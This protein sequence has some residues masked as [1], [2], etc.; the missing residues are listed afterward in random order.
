ML[1]ELEI[2]ILVPHAAKDGKKTRF[3]HEKLFRSLQ[4]CLWLW[5]WLLVCARC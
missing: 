5:V 4:V 1:S 3:S 2:A